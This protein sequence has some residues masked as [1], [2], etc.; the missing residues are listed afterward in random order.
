MDTFLDIS[1]VIW[2]EGFDEGATVLGAAAQAVTEYTLIMGSEGLGDLDEDSRDQLLSHPLLMDLP[3]GFCGGRFT[4]VQSH[5][6]CVSPLP[7][8]QSASFLVPPFVLSSSLTRGFNASV[9]HNP[10]FWSE[11]GRTLIH[12]DGIGA[13]VQETEKSTDKVWCQAQC[14]R[15]GLVVDGTAPECS[16]VTDADAPE[17][18]T[19]HSAS[20]SSLA[21]ILPALS[22]LE[23][24]SPAV[25][26]LIRN[27]YD[28]HVLIL[29]H[30][31]DHDT[32][33]DGSFPWLHDQLISNVCEISYSAL[34]SSS[35]DYANAEAVRF[36]LKSAN[37][38]M[39]VIIYGTYDTM[40]AST[41]ALEIELERQSGLGTTI[42]KIP[43]DDLLYCDW[44]GSLSL[45]ELRSWHFPSVELTVITNDRPN[46]LLRLFK[47]LKSARY[48]GDSINI[49]IN[50]EQTADLE[51]RRLVDTF[52]WQHGHVFVH[53][54]VV[55]AGL[56]IA[57]VES[58]YPRTNDSYAIILEDDVEVSPMFYAWSKMALLHYRYGHLE[59]K[60]P[61]LFGISLYQQKQIELRPEGRRPFDARSLFD[62]YGVLYRNTPYLS[63]IPCSWG[64][65]YFPEHWR[66]FHSYLM[67]RFSEAW[68][69]LREHVVPHVRS[70]RW[71]KSWKRFFIELVFLR[72]YVMLY[73]NYDDF[74]SLSTN[75]LEIG[76]HVKEQPR[77]I[78][79]QKKALFTLPLLTLPD[80]VGSRNALATGLL[81]L[82]E[83]QMP[84]WS[85]LP[86]LDLLGHLSSNQ[87]LEQC[88]MKRQKEL[89]GCTTIGSRAE[90]HRSFE[91]EE[92]FTCG[93]ENDGDEA[94]DDFDNMDVHYDI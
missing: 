63:Q 12:Q 33:R 17:D 61:S 25:C 79:D 14:Q 80:P 85:E 39:S 88:G 13:V 58:W 19:T 26:G 49:R 5:T 94:D 64:A 22:D 38:L 55:H 23:S 42:I 52:T 59:N 54:R 32:S 87:E 29:S 71:A 53:H 92:L 57:I 69:P 47:S 28:A 46:S 9:G 70:N 48:F 84:A 16:T 78:Y 4:K 40:H 24:F 86:V 82:P 41:T 44:I 75:H 73:P 35:N 89:I 72:G 66:E 18:Q 21:I 1:V 20:S 6:I 67:V 15:F 60:I 50:Q 31:L 83:D 65:V 62:A 3:T 27:G 30:N 2:A 93:S 8:T 56:L 91:A 43:Q 37:E 81:D 34:H 68:L 51:T 10:N 90:R 76:S 45:T 36:W 77:S 7:E 11:F 74:V